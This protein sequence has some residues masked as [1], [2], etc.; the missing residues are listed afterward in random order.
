MSATTVSTTVW[1]NSHPCSSRFGV[2]T[3]TF[4]SPGGRTRAKFQCASAAPQRSSVAP[5]AQV[6]DR[7]VR[8]VRTDEPLDLFRLVALDALADAR[9][10]GLEERCLPLIWPRRQSPTSLRVSVRSMD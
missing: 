4:I 10:R 3:E 2:S 5:V 9:N 8:V 1:S 6:V 7:D